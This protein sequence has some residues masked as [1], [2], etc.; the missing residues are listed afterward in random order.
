LAVLVIDKY[1]YGEKT[2]PRDGAPQAKKIS[3]KYIPYGDKILRP[4]EKFSRRNSTL[5]PNDR[6][7]ESLFLKI[8]K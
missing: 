1:R 4:G 6:S 5:L 7:G 3:K 2:F 8:L